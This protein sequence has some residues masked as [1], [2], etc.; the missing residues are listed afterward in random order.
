MPILPPP[1][2]PETTLK[3]TSRMRRR[4]RACNPSSSE[5]P[6]VIVDEDAGLGGGEPF[7]PPQVGSAVKHTTYSNVKQPTDNNNEK[8]TAFSLRQRGAVQGQPTAA[9]TRAP[10]QGGAHE[11]QG[12]IM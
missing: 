1:K 12:L 10:K 4:G 2:S 8:K 3:A 11:A 7:S 5:V 6:A 9:P